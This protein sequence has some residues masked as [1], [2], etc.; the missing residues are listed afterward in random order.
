MRLYFIAEAAHPYEPLRIGLLRH[1]LRSEHDLMHV[2]PVM[3]GDVLGN[4][5][6]P[7]TF[8]S[9]WRTQNVI[10]LASTI[11]EER[12]F[13]LVP[14]LADALEL[15]G[16]NDAEIL[17]H[18]RSPGEHARGCWTIDAILS[19]HRTLDIISVGH[20]PL[21]LWEDNGD[22]QCWEPLPGISSARSTSHG[23][24]RR[25]GFPSL[26]SGIRLRSRDIAG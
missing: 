24:S 18:C 17:G 21:S 13:Y 1:R 25:P 22:P 4:P 12:S 3:L 6:D 23:P 5:F 26:G 2:V 19:E 20:W 14:T 7:V 8:D 9:C 10:A 15:S 16:C 11:Y